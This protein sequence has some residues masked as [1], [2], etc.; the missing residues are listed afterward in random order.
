MEKPL[1]IRLHVLS[2]IHIGCD[3]VYEPTNFVIDEQRKKLIEFDPMEFVKSLND[4]QRIDFT[5]LCEGDNLL[6]ILKF[7]KSFN[8]KIK[9][10]EIDIAPS[11]VEHY[12]K[13]LA[14]PTFDKKAVINQFTINKTAYNPQTN[15]PYIPGTALKGALRTA[16]L[17]A[18]AKV[19]N[20]S[21]A[22]VSKRLEEDLLKGSFATDPFRMV[23]VS[24][25][26]PVQKAHT[27]ITYAVNKKKT[28]SD[29]A[30]LSEKGSVYQIFE[31][32]QPEA[33][34][35]GIINIES[36]SIINNR[37]KSDYLLNEAH[38]F[39]STNQKDE[40]KIFK[41][42]LE[43]EHPL[44]DTK[45]QH[46][47]KKSAFLIRL[48]RHSG[49]EALTIEGNR[50]IKIMQG[51]GKQPKYLDHATT[52]WLASDEPKP[53]TNGDLQPFGWAV[54]EVLPFDVKEGIYTA[55]KQPAPQPLTQTASSE[56][57]VHEPTKKQAAAITS[58][59]IIWENATVVWNPGNQTLK[60]SKDNQKAE[61]KVPDK[62]IVPEQYHE[63]LF[64]KKKS[65]TA[66][67]TVE[68]TGN[69]FKI[70]KIQ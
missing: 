30:L 39:Y 61:M 54:L 56:P 19:S 67:V 57:V 9:G 60:T 69:G 7:V 45:F 48:G 2:P 4:K 24:D 70:I 21:G 36:S 46:N 63:S 42:T 16:Y 11:L 28:E 14:M 52:L 6:A 59:T 66:N 5:K 26:M 1:K 12:K 31:S 47:F 35:E 41:D 64:T 27:A 51:Q 37:I 32:I 34:F 23:K 8:A 18:L 40:I 10:R 65:V 25:L 33:V 43:I 17:S 13:V 15:E 29:K 3:D 38:R 44:I 20:T 22:K 55:K 68:K 50:S 49:A 58:E 62:S 53:K